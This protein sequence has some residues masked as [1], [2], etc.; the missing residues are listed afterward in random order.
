MTISRSKWI[1]AALCVAYFFAGSL[2]IDQP[3]LQEDEVLFARGLY[4]PLDAAQSTTVFG[5]HVPL[6]QM[7]YLGS[8]KSWLWAPLLEVFG[9]SP[10]VVRL[11]AVAAGALTIWLVFLIVLRV[12]TAAAALVSAALLA[13]DPLFLWLTRCDWGP[14]ALE[15]LLVA[16]GVWLLIRFHDTRRD[17]WLAAGCF[18]FGLALW[19]KTTFVWMAFGLLCGAVVVRRIFFGLAT[20]RRL[21]LALAMLLLGAYPLVRYNVKH[22]GETVSHTARFEF[23][24][25]GIRFVRVLDALKGGGIPGYLYRPDFLIHP[26]EL[27]YGFADLPFIAALLAAPFLGVAGRCVALMFAGSFALMAVT[28]AAGESTH[29][30]ILLWPLPHILMALLFERLLSHGRTVG[31]IALALTIALCATSAAV[32][33]THFAQLLRNGSDPPWSD[34][35]IPLSRA[36]EAQ[37]RDGGASRILVMDW[38]IIGPAKFLTGGRLPLMWGGDRKRIEPGDVMV[39]Y[40]PNYD[41]FQG[42]SA[43]LAEMARHA[44]CR[45]EVL[46]TLRDSHNV[47]VFRLIQCSRD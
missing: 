22:R 29:H 18:V 6:M 7:S 28:R 31:G 8:L 9:P 30:V 38:G 41:Q 3:G 37:F 2:W 12:A 5:Y 16:L 21:A 11:P 45:L 26:W 23:S 33:E 17:R 4:G 27:R 14:V 34:A 15:H 39:T 35:N 19:N 20:R 24:R 46:D 36:I 13:F 42:T 1:A 32:T 10:A 47:A 25:V 43:R 44:N 40:V